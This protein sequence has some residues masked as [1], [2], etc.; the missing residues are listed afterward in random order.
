[1]RL[2]ITRHGQTQWNI[3]RRLQGWNDSPLTRIGVKRA[4]DLANRLSGIDFDYVYTSDQ[5]RA[6]K[7]ADIVLKDKTTRKIQLDSLREIGF[8]SWEG[9]TLEEIEEKY[10]DGFNTYLNDPENYHPIEGESIFQLFKRVSLA[11][12]EI[13]KNGGDNVLIVSHGVT[14]RALLCVIKGIGVDGFKNTHILA[15]TSLSIFDYKENKFNSIC[16][17]DTSHFTKR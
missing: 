1:L 13:L 8:G 4:N 11:L 5:N 9:M 2:Y 10:E 14:I 16:E 12:D 7:T 15:G 6:I 17:G 3:E